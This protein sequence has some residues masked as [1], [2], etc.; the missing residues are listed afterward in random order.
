MRTMDILPFPE[1]ATDKLDD[2]GTLIKS[3]IM[4]KRAI[5]PQQSLPL[6]AYM[7][8]PQDEIARERWTRLHIGL[9]YRRRG[10][11]SKCSTVEDH[12]N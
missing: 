3:R 1:N 10:R 8:W 6:I 11:R 5:Y 7:A 2:V 9:P 4:G 12:R